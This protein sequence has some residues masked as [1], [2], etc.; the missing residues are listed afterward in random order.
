M[1][2]DAIGIASRD[3]K[4]S[5]KF[6]DLL[7]VSLKEVADEHFEGTTPSGVRIMLDSFELMKK[8]NPDWPEPVGSGVILCFKQES[9]EKVDILFSKITLRTIKKIYDFVKFSL[10]EFRPFFFSKI[11]F[12]I[13]RII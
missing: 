5:I 9:S 6:Y 3:I 7:G 12:T 13:C 4:K 8:L 10:I 2:L 1:S 11:V